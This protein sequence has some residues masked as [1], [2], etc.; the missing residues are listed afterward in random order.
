[1]CMEACR[2]AR[3]VKDLSPGPT[4][5]LPARTRAR[6]CRRPTAGRGEARV[7]QQP[8]SRLEAIDP[9]HQLHP[10][11]TVKNILIDAV[12]MLRAGPGT[13]P[14][15]VGILVGGGGGS[16]AGTGCSSHL[17]VSIEHAALSTCTAPGR[18]AQ[19]RPRWILLTL[20]RYP[21]RRACRWPPAKIGAPR[22]G[23]GDTM[24]AD[25]RFNKPGALFRAAVGPGN[26][27]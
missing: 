15:R 3:V 4:C 6:V 11:Q 12:S 25:R 2:F 13:R 23:A 20:Q 8:H 9:P 17:R 18:D 5:D 10:T 21:H 22:I 19:S 16:P 7:A 14:V 26:R 27:P 1:M 24:C